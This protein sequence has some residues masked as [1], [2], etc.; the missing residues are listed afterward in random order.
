M[1]L[2]TD[3][4]SPLSNRIEGYLHVPV[5]EEAIAFRADLMWRKVEGVTAKNG[6][7]FIGMNDSSQRRLE[8][9]LKSVWTQMLTS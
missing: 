6:L 5:S 4:S 7:Q 1:L 9:L 3:V 8:S 2:K